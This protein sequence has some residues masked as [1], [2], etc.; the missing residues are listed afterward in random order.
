MTS[1][2]IK[3]HNSPSTQ[4]EGFIYY[5]VVHRRTVRKISTS[6]RVKADEWNEHNSSLKISDRKRES[7]ITSIRIS[8]CRDM[9]RLNT[10]IDNLNARRFDYTTAD[11]VEEFNLYSKRYSF[12]NYMKDVIQKLQRTGRVGTAENYKSALNSFKKFITS[13]GS[14]E[15]VGGDIMLDSIS[16]ELMEK[17]EAWQKAIGNIPNTI[18]FYIRIFRA[19]YKRAVADKI[20]E[21]RKPFCRVYTGV[22]KTSKRALTLRTLRLIKNLDLSSMPDLDFARDIFFLSLYL[23]GMSFIDLCFLL[24]SDLRNGIITYRRRKTGRELTIAWTKEMQQILDKYPPNESDYLIPIIKKTG[25]NERC[26]YKNACYAINR[27]VKRLG[28]LVGAP[29]Y[30]DWSLYR[31][32]HSWASLARDR[33]V[34]IEVISQALGHEN[35]KTTQIYLSSLETSTIDRA[36]DL[37][38]SMIE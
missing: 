27:N 33:G 7:L 31:A 20:I 18:S 13:Q 29:D 28:E 11:I 37:V 4:N 30:K 17:Y 16:S 32:R 14:L 23:R 24:K 26:A 6:Y 15:F 10:I 21:D 35:E 22:Y 12:V 38:I 2:K 5:Q 34:A 9:E 8:I 3:Y 1:I 25:I 19:V 36:N